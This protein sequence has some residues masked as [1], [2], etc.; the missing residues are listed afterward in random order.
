MKR[1]YVI[2]SFCVVLLGNLVAAEYHPSEHAEV[3]VLICSPSNEVYSRFGH[4]AI[5]ICDTANR[6]DEVFDYG[7]FLITD[8]V[9]FA[10]NFMTGKTYYWVESQSFIIT[11]WVYRYQGRGI[12]EYKL[13]L[14]KEEKE[15]VISYLLRNVDLKNREYLYN[16]FDDNCATRLRDLFEKTIPELQWNGVTKRVSWRDLVTRY[17]DENTWLGYGI[18]VAIGAPADK[19]VSESQLMFLPDYLG[20]KIA[21][22]TVGE[23]R[24][25]KETIEVLPVRTMVASS[26]YDNPMLFLWI[27][28][29]VFMLQTI[30]ELVTK[31]RCYW[32]DILF[33]VI[34][35]IVGCVISFISFFSIHSLVFP[36]YNVLWLCPLHLVFALLWIIPVMRGK[37]SWYF[38]CSA[39]LSILYVLVSLLAGQAIARPTY[40]VL[41]IFIMR[42]VFYC[43]PV[44]RK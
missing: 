43:V 12:R 22:A 34:V 36:N 44:R 3:S 11:K 13:L 4:A 38:V 7:V 33:F 5:R 17:V 28:A 32:C 20:Q 40:P 39:L 8:Y 26:K 18:Q 41:L 1:L 10:K 35:G 16:F 29:L 25:S 24:L 30:R 9:D 27:I 14:T 19:E 2:V 21:T 31:K 15:R 37:L 23:R 42:A 6:I